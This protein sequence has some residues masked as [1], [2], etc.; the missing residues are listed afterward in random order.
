MTKKNKQRID[1]LLVDRGLVETRTKAQALLMA[2][3]VLVG[4]EKVDKAGTMID[5]EADITL[6][7]SLPYVGRG[8]LKLEGAIKDFNIDLKGLNII[9][10]G[11]STGG[12]TDCALQNGARQAICVDVG[13]GLLDIK[14]RSDDRVKVFEGVN[15]RHLEFDVI[16]EKSDIAFFDLSFISVEKVIEKIKE[17]LVPQGKVLCLVKPQFEVGRGEVG[18]GGIVRDDKIREASLKKVKD[19]VIEKG[20]TVL[21]ETT[22]AIKGAKGNIEYWLYLG[23]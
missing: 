1:T 9:D 16:G 7:E 20:F 17:F 10:V 22:S 12:F 5:V 11:S 18:K 23:V 6:K 13:K 21:G 2:G 3:A 14:L 19:F 15:F 4:T 8:G